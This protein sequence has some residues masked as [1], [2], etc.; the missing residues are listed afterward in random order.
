MQV[1]TQWPTTPLAPCALT[2]G[3]FDGVHR[4]HQ[5]LVQALREE[6]AAHNL[7]SAALTFTDMPY[8]YFNPAAC[9]RLLTLAEE[10]IAAFA[11]LQIDQLAIV[12]FDAAIAEQSAEQFIKS[13]LIDKLGMQRLVIGPDF[14]L[15]KDR[16]GNAQALQQLGD[17]LG[18]TVRVLQEKLTFADEPISSTRVRGCVEDGHMKTATQLLGSPFLLAGDVVS[19]Q[20]LGRTIGVPTINFQPHPRKVLP[21][22]GIY[23]VRAYFDDSTT[24][25]P[26][27][28]NI[29]VRPTVDGKTLALEFHVIDEDIPVPPQQ[30]RLEII[31]RLRNEEKFNSLDELV[32]QMWRDIALAREILR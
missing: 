8:K 21:A 23:A 3:T 10:K 12:P 31:E 2:I 11:K 6:A 15:G 24:P 27:A 7:A 28:L 20:Q 26:A 1:L 13:I 30:V 4:G 14:A 25:H 18:F 16:S 22:Y 29:G 9:P 5:L 32:T 17:K 19:G